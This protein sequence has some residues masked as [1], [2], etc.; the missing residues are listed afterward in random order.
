MK[1]IESPTGIDLEPEPPR[2][3][4]VSKRAGLVVL[5]V[6]AI[7]IALIGFGVD[8]ESAVTEDWIPVRRDQGHNRRDGRGESRI[9]AGASAAD[10]RAECGES[11]VASATG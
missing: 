10:A 8:A 7:V 6:V 9:G 5:L 1:E 3:V 4:R 2:A 11:G